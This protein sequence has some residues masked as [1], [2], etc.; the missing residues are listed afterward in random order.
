MSIEHLLCE[1]DPQLVDEVFHDDPEAGVDYILDHEH[2][3]DLGRFSE[4]LASMTAL[5]LPGSP[6]WARGRVLDEFG[7]L[8]YMSPQVVAQVAAALPRIEQPIV[9][10]KSGHGVPAKMQQT[11]RSVTDLFRNAAANGSGVLV[12]FSA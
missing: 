11:L 1:V 9:H 4:T 10:S 12:F 7:Q 5:A 2:V 8:T 6:F 3:V